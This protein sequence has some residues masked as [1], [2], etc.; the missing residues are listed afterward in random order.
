MV[1]IVEQQC[2]LARCLCG[3]LKFEIWPAVFMR[4][5]GLYGGVVP[6]AKFARD[7]FNSYIYWVLRN[8]RPMLVA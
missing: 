7:G 6:I 8:V 3:M 1:T 5:G 2:A 4:S